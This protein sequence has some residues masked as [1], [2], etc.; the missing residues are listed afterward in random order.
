MDVLVALILSCSLHPDDNLVQGLAYRMSVA[1]QFF[2]GD[3]SN[4]NTYDSAKSTAEAMRIANAIKTAGGRPAVGLMAVPLD[5][6]A[7]FGR[8]P[9]DLFDGCTN[10]SIG[11][12]MLSDFNRLCIGGPTRTRAGPRL[13][14]PPSRDRDEHSRHR[15]ACDARG[16]EA[17]GRAA[18]PRR[19]FARRA[20]AGLP[21]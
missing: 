18:G 12:A 11:T 21:G 3:L 10:I 7:R 6:A 14:P 4:L 9:E 5:W 1:N 19:R 8:A 16:R 20:C 2:V 15:R 13:H 17:G